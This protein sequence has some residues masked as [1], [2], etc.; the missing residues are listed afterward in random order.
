MCAFLITQKKKMKEKSF[1]TPPAVKEKK[2]LSFE[3]ENLEEDTGFL[4]LKVSNLWTDFHNKALKK[5]SSLTHMQY[6]ILAGIYRLTLHNTTYVTQTMLSGHTK[7]EPA[8]LTHAFR[9][10]EAKGYLQRVTHPCN[11]KTKAVVLTQEGMKLMSR[12]VSSIVEADHKFFNQLGKNSRFFN[13]YLRQLL[14][15][16]L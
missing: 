5:H 9:G 8:T 7:I 4:M 14:E 11:V 12:A 15:T 1:H 2:E 10:L 13:T 6:T 3:I 16:N